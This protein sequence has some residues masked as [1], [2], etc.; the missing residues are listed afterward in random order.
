[1]PLTNRRQ[2]SRRGTLRLLDNLET[3]SGPA[4]SAYVPAGSRLPR[5]EGIPGDP[6]GPLPDLEKAVA[7]SPTGAVLFWGEPHRYLVLPPFPLREER[8]SRGYDVE[9]LR[10][11][12]KRDLA[13]ALIL[14]RLSAYAI[15]VFQGEK[16]VSSKVGTGHVH[17]R[18]KK[19]GSS[20]RRFER[21]RE[22]Q[23]EYFFQ[24]ICVRVREQLEPHARRLDYVVYGGERGTLL[25]FRQH[26]PFL[27]AFDQRTSGWLLNVRQPRQASLEAAIGDAW[28]SR[29]VQWHES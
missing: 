14:V 29:V 18:H 26:C 3:A 1:M 15:G 2:L 17:S 13:V 25:S 22:K 12:L 10:S 7:H 16:L 4:V 6:E 23:M 27:A 8:V 11:F 20:Q 19:G 9:P 28:S 21:G 24:R 5:T